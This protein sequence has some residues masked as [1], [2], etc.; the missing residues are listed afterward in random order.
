ME[1]DELEEKV[2]MA[3]ELIL[4]LVKRME[5]IESEL[6]EF[7]KSFLEQYKETLAN[8]SGQIEKS[9]KR[10]DDQKI[11][12]QID[13][14]KDLVGTMPKVITVKNEHHHHFGA[15]SKNLITGVVVCFLITA[16]SVGT[17]LYLKHE[18][19]RMSAN[20]IKFRAIRQLAP[21]WGHWA[22]TTYS[23][24]PKAMEENTVKLE[25]E[26]LEKAYAEEVAREKAEEAK[27]ARKRLDSLKKK[28]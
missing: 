24:N 17:A 11:S 10:Y 8:I 26:A 3:E 4:G 1:Q 22:D 27:Q 21:K 6:P 16:S 14:V 25:N 19:N 23:R 15:W 20:S 5:V 28:D 7:L 2:T 9:N 12:Q 13:Q 18:N